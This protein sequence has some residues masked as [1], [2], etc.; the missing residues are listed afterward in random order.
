MD[1]ARLAAR[2]EAELQAQGLARTI[3]DPD[4]LRQVAGLLGVEDA[5]AGDRRLAQARR[6]LAQ[7]DVR[8][9]LDEDL[10]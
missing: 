5:R 7:L 10:P 6:E 8:I 3:C 9:R 4:V 2:A 1:D